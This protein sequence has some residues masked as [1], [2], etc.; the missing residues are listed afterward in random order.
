MTCF[1]AVLFGLVFTAALAHAEVTVDALLAQNQPPPGV[2]F[3]VFEQSDK[4][5]DWAMPEVS[6]QVKKL[7][8]RF[9]NL[10]IAVVTHGLEMFA[11]QASGSEQNRKVHDLARNFTKQE[12]IPVHVCETFAGVRSVKAEAFPDYVNVS[13]YAPAQIEDYKALG[14]VL[15]KLQRPGVR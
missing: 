7:R 2:V 3:E 4:A 6:A 8:E 14:Y 10:E 15:V 5:L 9:P 12:N 11:L 1:K 13:P